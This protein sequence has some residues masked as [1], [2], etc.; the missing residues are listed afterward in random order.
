MVANHGTRYNLMIM[1]HRIVF[2]FNIGNFFNRFPPKINGLVLYNP[3]SIKNGYQY[4]VSILRFHWPLLK[5]INSPLIQECLDVHD[6][7]LSGKVS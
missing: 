2:H 3:V 4:I 5:K 6:P 1:L 7:F